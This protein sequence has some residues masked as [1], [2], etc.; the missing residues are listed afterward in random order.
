MSLSDGWTR[1]FY[2]TPVAA[3]LLPV[4]QA[5]LDLR[6]ACI[7]RA[8]GLRGGE[9]LLDQCCGA[10]SIALALARKG[11][12]VV[13]V[14]ISSAFVDQ[15]RADAAASGLD[16]ELACADA[17]AWTSPTPCDA[18]F[19]WGT[20]FGCFASDDANR[21]ML[22]CAWASLRPGARFALDYY[23]V[24][25][26]LAGFRPEFSYERELDGRTVRVE[27]RSV[28]DLERGLL[29]QD[30]SFHDAGQV[31]P[32]PRTT[33][34]LYLPAELAAM[35][36]SV[37]FDVQEFLGGYDGRPLDLAAPRCIVVVHRSL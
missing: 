12:P 23:N 32:M 28:L 6:V 29:H 5:E 2:E 18:G 27:R 21:A 33:T 9:R 13:G 19:N 16:A 10:G 22:A 11:H 35:L 20:G 3:S 15:A 7:E 1:A 14:D 25:G 37:G 8:L 31:T 17:T 34:R 26:V 30:W 4:S 24:A 36:V